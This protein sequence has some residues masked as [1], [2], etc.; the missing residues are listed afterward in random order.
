MISW[1]KSVLFA[2]SLSAVP[3]TPAF[4]IQVDLSFTASGF[5][6]GAST[7]P[8]T[9]SFTFDAPSISSGPTLLTA[10]NLTIDGH[11]Y[12]LPEVGFDN[13]GTRSVIGGKLNGVDEVKTVTNDFA[14][15]W[16]PASSTPD[17]FVYTT[18]E[19]DNFFFATSFTH[20]SVTAA[21]IPEPS[22][23]AMMLLGFAGL[24]FAGYRR[25]RKAACP[26]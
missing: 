7:D 10:V 9:G 21:A 13:Q 5:G 20:F 22:T 23:W 16:T 3:L 25:A 2:V 6:A 8:V 17:N 11:A 24:G 18:S 19:L 26:G 4:A 15:Q 1:L 14:L 12:T